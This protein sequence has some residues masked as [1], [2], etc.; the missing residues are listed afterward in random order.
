MSQHL[1]L[2]AAHAD[3]R[4]RS[5]LSLKPMTR[6]VLFSLL[7]AP[8]LAV[9]LPMSGAYAQ[10]GTI[11]SYVIAPAPLGTA[12]S[13]FAAA[14]DI[15]LSFDAEQTRGKQSS[16]LNG[17]YSV[18]AGLRAL[19][20]GSGLQAVHL[21]K[22]N[23][24]LREEA[25]G[26]AAAEGAAADTMLPEVKVTTRVSADALPDA[27]AG[28]QVA[29][30]GRLGLLGNKGVMDTPFNQTSY[31]A[32]L[33]ADQSATTV[34]DVLANDPSV[35]VNGSGLTSAA[36]AGDIMTIRGFSSRSQ[37][38]AFDGIY[39]I[40]PTRVFPVET[41]ER[42]EVLKGPNALLNGMA[43]NG[44]VGGAIN[45][46]PKRAGETPL[47][48]LTMTTAT[49]GLTGLHADI[50]RRFGDDNRWGVRFN[51]IYRD[52]GT[53]IDGQSVNMNVAT[54]GIDFR[55]AKLRASL[56]AGYQNL[57]TQAP[58][59]AAGIGLAPGFSAGVPR[60]PKAESQ[61][62]QNW[63]F[64][65]SRSHYA[66]AKLEY[67]L[68]Q[69]WT[70]YGSA[71]W[72]GNRDTFLST[73]KYVM[74]AAGNALALAYY[75]PGFSDRKSV[76]GGLRGNLQTGGV[77][78]EINL[79]A[80]L[81]QEDS[82]YIF[83]NQYGFTAFPTNIYAATPVA[84]P[85]LA[86][87][88]SRAPKRS[89]L[90]LPTVAL[91]DTLSWMEGR[92]ALTLGV[93]QQRVRTNAYDEVS[94]LRTSGYK[95]S[96]TTP[97]LAILVKATNSLSLY[98][99]YV[100]GLTQGPTAPPGSSNAN[101]MFAPIKTK[102]A[103]AGVK[104][105]FG[106]FAVTASVFEITR[107]VGINVPVPGVL[108]PEYR[109][110]GEQR[111][112]GAE[113]N[114]F[115]ELARGWR[116]LGGIAYTDARLT[117]TEGSTT[118]GKVA[119]AVPRWQANLGSELDLA[120]VPGMTLSARVIATSSQYLDVTN[121]NSIPGWAR[122]DVGLRYRTRAFDKPLVLRANIEN[123]FGRDYWM[124]AADGWLNQGMPRTVTLSASVDF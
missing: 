122:W 24:V 89:D 75:Y 106:H 67:D 82:G 99:N 114:A 8:P 80:S 96:A 79:N 85:S 73:D 6:A 17:P 102:Q 31:T 11:R 54:V 70:V 124:T 53:A 77:R 83:G 57:K 49:G 113:L 48:R 25:P 23:Y 81:L 47:T 35:R 18:E 2:Q 123:L 14:A 105:D 34:A 12:L 36:G 32:E 100:E 65:K 20:A 3:R 119:V 115:G 104:Y 13:N 108:Q 4:A 61:I 95:A 121:L 97:A 92:V 76:Q 116:L 86:G 52:G 1:S 118:D 120:V 71:G 58:T 68:N 93:R 37:D 94:G 62:S 44:S 45:A 87:F 55:D 64:S 40:A 74:D 26:R 33:I 30:G 28:G 117:R 43:P 16:G 22:G 9:M 78:H 41:L 46:V 107:P 27:F 88:S 111:N 39:G 51:G 50:A 42:L 7:L 63:E 10:S 109:M 84:M 101:Q 72:S 91:A 38:V 21:Q 5:G 66:L 98:G 112:R 56:D 60:P 69:D 103:E 29:A 19:L 15:T 110:A 90:S 59:G